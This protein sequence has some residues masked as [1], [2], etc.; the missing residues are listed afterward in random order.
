MKRLFI[1]AA[2]AVCLFL[3]GCS[4]EEDAPAANFLKATIDGQPF[5]SYADPALNT[6]TVPNTFS[7]SFGQ[8]VNR[9]NG[10]NDT[11]LFISTSL[12]RKLIYISFPKTKKP[13]T[14]AIYRFSD[15]LKQPAAYYMPVKQFADES[16]LE[17]YYTRNILNNA[18]INNEKAGVI[19]I[20]HIDWRQHK[21]EGTFSFTALGY[22]HSETNITAI[23]KQVS[24]TNGQFYYCWEEDF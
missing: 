17:T 15:S 13:Q 8:A 19:T 12:N 16:G 6:D 24:V 11:C 22:L 3:S 1:L 7:F 18:D 10:V 9:L 20:S 14:F 2:G 5:L 21:I 4:G 23:N